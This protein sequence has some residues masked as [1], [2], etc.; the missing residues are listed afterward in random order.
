MELLFYSGIVS[1]I[2]WKYTKSVGIKNQA[3]WAG[4]CSYT[5]IYITKSCGSINKKRKHQSIYK[6]LSPQKKHRKTF[7]ILQKS[8]MTKLLNKKEP[9][10]KQGGGWWRGEL[11][12]LICV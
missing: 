6:T 4:P 12:H 5:G 10:M 7:R 2:D 8:V 11:K 9:L 3:F 1:I